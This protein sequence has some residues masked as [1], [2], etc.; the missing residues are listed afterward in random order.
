[1]NNR[2]ARQNT[3]RFFPPAL[4]VV[5]LAVWL[6]LPALG[7]TIT[8]AFAN[9]S[10]AGSLRQAIASANAAGT[11]SSIIFNAALAGQTI[12]LTSG[13][14]TLTGNATI[15]ASALSGGIS[16]SGN[17]SSRV[18]QIAA[19]ATVALA[20]L[21]IRN[22]VAPAGS[23]PANSGG[24]ILNQ[25]TLTLTNCTLTGNQ[26]VQSF[27][28]GG[29]GIENNN[30]SLA[31]YN[32]TLAGNSALLGGGIDSYPT[33]ATALLS[34]CTVAGNT[35]T[36]NGG[37]CYSEGTLIVDQ[38]TLSGNQAGALCGGINQYGGALTL[39]NSIVA[40]N[41]QAT[42]GD[43]A[44]S[45]PITF[46]GAN[47]TSGTPL[48]SPLG[49][50]GGPT[51]TMPPQLASPAIDAAIGSTFTT[52][53]RGFP[54]VVGAAADLGATEG[55]LT[56]RLTS[57][58]KLGNGT[59]QFKF[60]YLSGQT[61]TVFACTNVAMPLNTWSSLGLATESSPGQFQFTDTQAQNFR[62]RF[63]RVT[64]P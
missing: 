40:G 26:A 36:Q 33:A 21:T 1:M 38:S 25:G 44:A 27:A 59:V 41:T 6:A 20:A 3:F 28:A 60:T 12:T 7:G 64:S 2:V 62:Q 19:G 13:Q 30:A 43:L 18:L 51:Q 55:G 53:Q 54:R 46:A 57:L 48:L 42:G 10:G 5:G 35:A 50:Y 34:Q 24:G 22:G 58:S 61:Y 31:V 45:N 47:L 23:Y 9:D 14:L 56:L 17:N 39:K 11:A 16:L 29:G 63:Y 4:R 49:N 37:G 15:D 32:S 8:V 52:D